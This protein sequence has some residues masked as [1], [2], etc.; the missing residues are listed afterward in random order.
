MNFA[1]VV[2][3]KIVLIEVKLS[4]TPRPTT[5]T[6]IKILQKDF[7]D[8]LMPGYVLHPGDVTPPLDLGVTAIP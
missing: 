7:G 1:V 3:E 6:S 2:R 8:T 4:A 5:A